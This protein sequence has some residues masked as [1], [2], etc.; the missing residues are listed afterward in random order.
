MPTQI[1]VIRT[2]IDDASL[3]MTRVDE[4]RTAMSDLVADPNASKMTHEVLA[5]GAAFDD[6]FDAA[7][8]L[9]D[10][11]VRGIWDGWTK[12]DAATSLLTQAVSKHP[13][14]AGYIEL[15]AAR[16]AAEQASGDL[17]NWI[18]RGGRAPVASIEAAVRPQ[19]ERIRELAAESLRA[20]AP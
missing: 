19:L 5:D 18:A 4:S 8:K 9:A 7:L 1:N 6:P 3:A 2:W 12:S 20:A 11:G 14:G 10:D 17:G 15:V 13:G 16:E